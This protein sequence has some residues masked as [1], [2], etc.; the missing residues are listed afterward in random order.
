MKVVIAL[1][2][3]V[4]ML[5]CTLSQGRN[6]TENYGCTPLETLTVTESCDYN[7]DGDCSVTVTNECICNYGYLRNR[8]TGLCVPADQCFP[9]IEPI[10]FPCLKD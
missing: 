1:F 6:Q 3:I 7:C 4:L 2:S 9:S 10:T 8:K 5:L